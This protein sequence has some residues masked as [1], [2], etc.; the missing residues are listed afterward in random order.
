MLSVIIIL[1]FYPV[2]RDMD[3]LETGLS[4]LGLYFVVGLLFGLLFAF[5]GGAKRIDPGAVEGSW[6]F[7]VLLIPGCMI[8]WPY[9][10][11]RWL[12]G[13]AP[14]VECSRHR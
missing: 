6:G 2:S 4:L 12:K 5:L 9:L 8:F 13:S 7:R 14:P 10:L 11:F 1:N 3:I